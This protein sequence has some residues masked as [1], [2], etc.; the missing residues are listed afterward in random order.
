MQYLPTPPERPTWEEHEEWFLKEMPK[1]HVYAVVAYKERPVG[2]FHCNQDGEI[3]IIIGEKSLW[4]RGIASDV[5][6]AALVGLKALPATQ[7]LK[8]Y[9]VIHPENIASQHV[10]ASNVFVKS[11]REARNGQ[12][13]WVLE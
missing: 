6:E 3:G 5:L 7:D 12:E 4:G 1:A 9:A 11:G 13:E 10:F 8:L 2:T